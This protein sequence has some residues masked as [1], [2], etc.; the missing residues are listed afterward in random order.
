MRKLL[1]QRFGDG[2]IYFFGS[3]QRAILDQGIAQELITEDG[4]ITPSGRR[5]L[6]GRTD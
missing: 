1:D 3:E 6:V 2:S 4:L 5:F